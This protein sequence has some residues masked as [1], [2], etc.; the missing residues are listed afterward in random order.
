MRSAAIFSCRLEGILQAVFAHN[1]EVK[2]MTLTVEAVYENGVL[3]PVQPLPLQERERVQVTVQSAVQT[4]P[5]PASGRRGYGLV[6]W[7]GPTEELDYLIEDADND[8]LEG[9]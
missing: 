9:P 3:K 4:A 6:P 1:T 7:N 5:A 2:T 8:P